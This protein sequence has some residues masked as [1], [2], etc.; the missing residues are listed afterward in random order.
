MMIRW[1]KVGISGAAIPSSTNDTRF[2][3]A[4]I[5]YTIQKHIIGVIDEVVPSV[6]E[7]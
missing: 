5:G 4:M 3:E 2:Q 6:L 7:K 1:I